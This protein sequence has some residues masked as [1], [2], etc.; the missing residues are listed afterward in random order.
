MS[1]STLFGNMSIEITS[2][3][4]FSTFHLRRLAVLS[5]PD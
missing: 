5:L 4:L 1:Y 2:A 3:K